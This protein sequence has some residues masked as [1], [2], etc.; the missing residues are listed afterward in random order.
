M[1]PTLA[2]AAILALGSG[3]VHSESNSMEF[4][5]QTVTLDFASPE[6]A[7]AAHVR[8]LPLY[9]GY[10][11]AVSSRWDD[12][13]PA[14]LKMRQTL[15]AHGY[16][17]TFYMNRTADG[18][19]G[20]DYGLI[21]PVNYPALGRRLAG[22]GFT[23][24]GHSLTH[25]YL[26][27]EARNEIFH[28]IMGIRADRESSTACPINTFSFPFTE[29]RNDNEGDVVQSDIAEIL[30]RAGYFQ[31][32]ETWFKDP[33]RPGFIAANLLP[34]DGRDI[35][36]AF[37][38]LL[39]DPAAQ[40]RE[41]NITFNMH[42]W[43]STPEAWAKF[44]KQLAKYG[45]NPRWWYCNESE[46]A[47]YRYQFLHSELSSRVEG[48][49]LVVSLRRPALVDLN[50]EIPLT[51]QVQGARA[52]D[53]HRIECSTAAV[54]PLKEDPCRFDLFH[55]RVQS[56]PAAVGLVEFEPGDVA[57]KECAVFPG[58]EAGVRLEGSR[59]WCVAKAKGGLTRIRATFRLPLAYEAGVI[60]EATDELP[61]GRTLE[62]AVTLA[63]SHSCSDAKY[64]AGAERFYVQLDFVRNG[65]AG[66]LYLATRRPE[67]ILDA[68]F[69]RDGFCVLGPL[70]GDLA[71]AEALAAL[72]AATNTR[73]R[74]V[75]IDGASLRWTARDK[76]V[77]QWLDPEYIC[78]RGET[79]ADQPECHLLLTRLL[80]DRP[81]RLRCQID[82]QQVRAIYLN[83]RRVEN[84]ELN[85]QA[86]SN[87]LLLLSWSG[88]DKFSARHCGAFLR[89]THPA[90]LARA[91]GIRYDRES[92]KFQE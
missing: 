83:G 4:Y 75:S 48:A 47:A 37:A 3:S 55:D 81:M 43:Y 17:G 31:V 56:L 28:E 62:W 60:R 25:P 33:A 82:E 67:P 8:L 85:L 42:V 15:A 70:P 7:R 46:Y 19:Y 34:E 6:A 71:G 21:A 63:P 92:L 45:A 40:S 65:V 59:I 22:N 73:T 14:D 84:L 76:S 69:P 9:H 1:K 30:N 32:V 90:T 74:T 53:V 36:A 57:L 2:F 80:A 38:S 66:R 52:A 11:W 24:G 12:N 58:L 78:T 5:T 87:D 72:V 13:I 79:H 77:V 54:A 89:V 64:R 61:E 49:R 29:F 91:E 26:H 23:I 44:E 88:P 39:S 20:N 68:S 41:P 86:G 27:C 51:L 18:Y 35:D 10:D 16:R 50:H